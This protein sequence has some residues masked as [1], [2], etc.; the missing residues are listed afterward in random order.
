MVMLG[1]FASLTFKAFSNLHKKST[2]ISMDVVIKCNSYLFYL[3]IPH[4]PTVQSSKI[5]VD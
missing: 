3:S 2:K 1:C 5:K 4:Y